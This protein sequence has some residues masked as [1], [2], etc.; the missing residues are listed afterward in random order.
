M[1]VRTAE[2]HM[3]VTSAV[4]GLSSSFAALFPHFMIYRFASM[5]L[6]NGFHIFRVLL[7]KPLWR[8]CWDFMGQFDD[9]TLKSLSFSLPTNQKAESESESGSHKNVRVRG[10]PPGSSDG[11]T[12]VRTVLN[13]KQL[14]TLRWVAV[15]FI[16]TINAFMH[17]ALSTMQAHFSEVETLKP[18]KLKNASI[19]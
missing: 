2:I 12:R 8:S 13:E 10:K 5:V 9:K 6:S 15:R 17:A 4:W 14:H 7:S 16:L 1:D 18:R 11:K 19:N 3:W